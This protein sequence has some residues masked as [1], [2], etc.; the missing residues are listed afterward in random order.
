MSYITMK[1][2]LID[3]FLENDDIWRDALVNSS[4][5]H[6]RNISINE[7][8]GL[9]LSYPGIKTKR[10]NDEQISYDYRVDF[11]G[12]AISHTSIILDLYSKTLQYPNLYSRLIEFIIELAHH[13]NSLDINKY[14]DLAIIKFA[15]MDAVI[16]EQSNKI[17]D[18]LNK[19]LLIKSNKNWNFSFCE[20]THII[21]WI[22]LQEDIN[23]PIS[24]GYQGRRMPFYR[25]FEAINCALAD[26][27]HSLK[28]VILRAL[29]HTKPP[30]WKL[31]FNYSE[32]EKIS[33]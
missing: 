5:A 19:K 18:S 15:P 13:G 9:S 26:S 21:S 10:K 3:E 27:K 29:S 32:I 24:N 8:L 14:S 28:E 25:Y 11:K 4:F 31:D 22:A 1:S 12:V 2:R 20:L 6:T 17:F 16:L 7:E 23:Y 33:K 30:L